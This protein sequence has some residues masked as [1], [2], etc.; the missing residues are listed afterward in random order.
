MFTLRSKRSRKTAEAPRNDNPPGTLETQS[1]AA[2]AGSMKLRVSTTITM[3][4]TPTSS[5]AAVEIETSDLD[6]R[7]VPIQRALAELKAKGVV[8][9]EI[10]VACP[11]RWCRSSR[12]LATSTRGDWF[13]GSWGDKR[14]A[15]LRDALIVDS[16][17]F[18]LR[19]LR[20][21]HN[22]AGTFWQRYPLGDLN[23]QELGRLKQRGEQVY[24]VVVARGAQD[25][26]A[27]LEGEL[28]SLRRLPKRHR[29]P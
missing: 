8:V 6:A 25:D 28:V 20:G 23:A 19:V 9:Q 24:G 1:S 14:I 15:G 7:V 13:A 10:A 2:R 29:W 4:T 16:R 27:A 3:R 22:G 26:S 5:L 11:M 12:Y 18:R 21:K 17:G